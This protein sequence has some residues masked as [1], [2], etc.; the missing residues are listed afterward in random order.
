MSSILGTYK[1]REVSF[2]EGKGTYLTSTTGEKY[3]DFVSGIAVNSLGHCH[4][5]LVETIKKQSE[6]LWHV[7]NAFTIPEQERVTKR[8]T[9][10]TFADIDIFIKSRAEETKKRN[11][12]ERK[13]CVETWH[14]E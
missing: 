2:S 5:H 4:P 11:K 12:V 8:L 10:N 3:L 1:R 13:Y 14:P 9:D 6:Q 7:S